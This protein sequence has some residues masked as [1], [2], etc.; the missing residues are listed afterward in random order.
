MTKKPGDAKNRGKR[1]LPITKPQPNRSELPIMLNTNSTGGSDTLPVIVESYPNGSSN[2]ALPVV[3]NS[4]PLG[5]CSTIPVVVNTYAT[6]S[7]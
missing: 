6:K 3:V 5:S 2:N 1:K 7:I 4:Y